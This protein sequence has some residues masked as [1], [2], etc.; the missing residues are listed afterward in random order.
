MEDMIHDLGQESFQQAHAP[1]YDTLE[2]DSKKLLYS[3]CKNSLTLLLA[4][5]SLVNVKVKYGWSDKS[6]SSLLQ[7]VHDML[8]E[9]NTLP[10]SY[11][12]AKNILC[13]M[14]MEYQKIHVCPNGCI[15]YKH[16]F[17]E[18][19]KCPRCGVSQYKVKDDDECSS[20]ESTKKGLFIKGVTVSSYYSKV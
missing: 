7:V 14:G 5:L 9:E 8:L 16:E 10:K 13:L 12:Q 3:G 18:M 17:Q 1:M 20:D 2:T 19:H 11:Y 6:F 4:V 15:L